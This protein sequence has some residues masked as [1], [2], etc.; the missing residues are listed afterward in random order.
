[1]K[2]RSPK[3]KERD[4]TMLAS[5]NGHIDIVKELAGAMADPDLTDKVSCRVHCGSMS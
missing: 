3:S 4:V 5:K 1:M 2:L